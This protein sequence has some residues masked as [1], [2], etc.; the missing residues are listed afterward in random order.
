[1]HWFL[2]VL[3]AY[4]VVGV[5]IG[6]FIV[7]PSSRGSDPYPLWEAAKATVGWL[8]WLVWHIFIK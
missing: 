2:W 6:G 4:L 3:I 7:Y 8:P 5:L 1:M